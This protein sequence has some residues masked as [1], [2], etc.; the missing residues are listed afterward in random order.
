MPHRYRAKTKSANAATYG[1]PDAVIHIASTV[2]TSLH[3]TAHLT[4]GMNGQVVKTGK[5]FVVDLAGSEMV[6]GVLE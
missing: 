3:I 1:G 5:L 2:S 6:G 4:W